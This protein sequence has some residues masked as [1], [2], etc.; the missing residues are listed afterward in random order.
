MSN[1][2][3]NNL[4]NDTSCIPADTENRC[5]KDRRNNRKSSLKYLLFNGRRERIRREEDRGKVFF[6]DRYNPRLFAAIS[7]I[8]MLSITDAL[9]TLI[10]IANGSSEL[11]PIMAY[12]LRHGLLPF[13]IAKYTLTSIGVV[14]LLIFKNV[15]LCRV[16]IYTYSLFSAVIAAFVAVV[17]WEIFL[18]IRIH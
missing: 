8:L 11:N 15:F 14:I 4:R 9:L 13:I 7:A 16:K 3:Q 2:D 18:I 6:F 10:L 12:F 1:R 17:A 5:G